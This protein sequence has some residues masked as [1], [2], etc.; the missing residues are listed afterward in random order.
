MNRSFLKCWFI[1]FAVC[2]VLQVPAQTITPDLQNSSGWTVINRSVEAVHEDGKKAVRFNAAEGE[3]YMILKD[4]DFSNGVIEF[5]VKG[6]NVVQQS[7]VGLVFHG[8]DEKTYDAVYF[9]PFNFANPDTARRKRAVQYIAMPDHPWEKL[10]ETFPGKYENNVSPVPN[11]D[12]WFHV[13]L[14][15]DGKKVSVYVNDAQ[16]PSLEIDKL[17][18][19][20]S[21]GVALW[22]GNNSGGSFA[23]LTI[24]PL[25]SN[26]AAS[27]EQKSFTYGDNPQAGRYVNVGDAN[28]Y[29]EVYGAGKPLVLLHGGVYGY[30]SEFENLIPRLAENF[31]V[32]CIAT[33]GHGKSEIGQAP[34]TYKQRA[35]DAYKVI[36]GLTKDS[37]VVIGF[38]DG[39]YSA[40]KLAAL[41]PHVV[42]KVVAIGISDNPKKASSQKF[43]YTEAA[44]MK[45][46]SAFFSSRL[47]LMPEPARWDEALRK[48][49]KLYNDD[50][51][52]A[53]TF[54]KIKCPALIMSGD[55]DAYHT[56]EE[57]VACAKAI[58]DAR[59][60]IIPGCAHVVFFC[61][62]SAVWES[63]TPF[64]K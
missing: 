35:D 60:A 16:T 10:R 55:R 22:V 58:P 26:A 27:T 41:Y 20:T 42:K 2:A 43:N 9:R 46:D 45:T 18:N 12:G 3:G 48:L 31:Q 64:L 38:S 33:R 21:G 6:R 61:N 29:Y 19:T 57:V 32:I 25:G 39:G 54:G 28:L 8:R 50:Y 5:D 37:A 14:K 40:L 24:T 44:L 30:I 47:K 53:E 15:V 7:F 17:S 4:V 11:P 23:N 52:S 49:S 51:M 36:Q 63:L 62:F 13:K 34:F 59:L 56:V 1:G